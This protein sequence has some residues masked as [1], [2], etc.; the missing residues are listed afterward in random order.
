M[1]FETSPLIIGHRGAAGLLPENT[2]ESFQR[3]VE[4]GVA[5]I[6]LDV[7]ACEGT[8]VVIHD[9]KL[10]RTTNGSGSVLGSRLSELRALDAGNGCRIPLLVEVLEAIPDP[11]GINIE[12]KGKGTAE[13]LANLL[14]REPA[15][16]LLISSFDHVLLT[17]FHSQLPDYPAAPLFARWRDDAID[18]ATRFG[19]GFINLSRKL[20]TEKRLDLIH[21]SGLKTLVYTVNDETEASRFFR[22]GVWGIFT[23]FPDRF[24]ALRSN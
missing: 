8:L 16:S 19:G 5:A 10:D 6:E 9:D 1:T 11:V 12:L 24:Q 3:A 21:A 2:L 4:L 15:R 23:D 7:H 22:Q 13:L 20:A 17:R 14:P 18:S